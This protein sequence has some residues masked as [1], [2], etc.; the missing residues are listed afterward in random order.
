[1]LLFKCLMPI[2]QMIKKNFLIKESFIKEFCNFNGL[3]NLC[4][5]LFDYH[6]AKEEVKQM[7][8]CR[9]IRLKFFFFPY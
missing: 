5:M 4:V 9:F 3:G 6:R 8:K 7:F 1:M 2:L